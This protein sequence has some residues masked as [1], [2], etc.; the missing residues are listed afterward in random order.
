[1][2]G[3]AE[4]PLVA[5]SP[6]L[7]TPTRPY[8]AQRL[9][10]SSSLT[11]LHPPPGTFTAPAGRASD[12]LVVCFFL[13]FINLPVA[14]KYLPSVVSKSQP[15]APLSRAAAG[16]FAFVDCSPD[17]SAVG[18]V[19]GGGPGQGRGGGAG[20]RRGGDPGGGGRGGDRHPFASR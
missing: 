3:G 4:Y 7:A 9:F 19:S 2:A 6:C 5:T 10:L 13:P 12:L 15:P 11:L 14:A 18:V 16:I 20:G 17:D 1:V 8:S